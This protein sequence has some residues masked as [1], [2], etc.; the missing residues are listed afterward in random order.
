[1]LSAHLKAQTRPHHDRAEASPAMQAV[2][3]PRLTRAAY[4]DHLARLL[5]FYGPTEAALADV[6]GLADVLPDLAERLVKT[7]WLRDDLDRL[8]GGV[9]VPEARAPAWTVPE[10]LGVLYVVEGSTLGGRIIA[11]EL[12]RSVGVTPDDG[13]RFYAS[14]R[15]DRGARWTAFKSALD[16]YGEAH[17]EASDDAVRAASDTFDVLRTWMEAPVPAA[18]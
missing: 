1:M 10:A 5:A 2:V 6:D 17:P 12:A 4:R 16:A 15:D 14:Y 3:S 13:G 9:E 8:G 18:G 11:R 7:E